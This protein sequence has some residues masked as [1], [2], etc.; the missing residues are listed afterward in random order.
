MSDFSALKNAWNNSKKN[1]KS[2]PESLQAIY[3]QIDKNKKQNFMFYYGTIAILS[4]TLI[5]ISCFFYFVAPVQ[6]ILSRIGVGLMIGGLLLRIILEILT[7]TRSK[8]VH[9]QD[10]SLDA[11]NNAIAFH[12][13]RKRVHFVVA[14]FIIALYTIGFYMITPEFLVYLST[15][16]V[17]FFDGLY[18]ILAVFLFTQIR[19]GVLKEM[20]TLDETLSLKQELVKK[21]SD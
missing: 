2:S 8:K 5:G 9:V 21:E 3:D 11:I 20:E 15:T 17:I 7:A 4:I 1:I 13:F 18:L 19:K 14:P 10:N 12:E 6:D 16:S